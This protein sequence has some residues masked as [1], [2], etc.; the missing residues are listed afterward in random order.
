MK[1][2]AARRNAGDAGN[3]IPETVPVYCRLDGVC[4]NDVWDVMF[5][6]SGI[7]LFLIYA[8]VVVQNADAVIVSGT[9][10]DGFNNAGESTLQT[11]LLDSSIPSFPYW[12]NLVRYSDASGIY[13]GYNPST[14]RGWVLSANHISEKTSITVGGYS[15]VIIDKVPAIA[16]QN[17]TRLEH[18]GTPIDM[19]LYEFSVGGAAPIPPMPTVPI[20]SGTL[21]PGNSVL[22]AGRGMRSGA[23]TL[24]EDTT[25]PYAWGTPGESD[26]VPFRWGTNTVAATGLSA[27]GGMVSFS[28][29]FSAPGFGTEFE[30]QG[31]LGDSG[32]SGFVLTG[33]GDWMLAGLLFS[34]GDGP[35]AG[36]ATDPAGYGDLTYF[37]NLST[38][39]TL[40]HGITGSLIPEPTTVVYGF[41]A[42]MVLIVRRK[43][44]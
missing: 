21:S 35:D 37:A 2:H 25:A 42:T 39:R 34:V 16:N 36:T 22:M 14:M 24:A 26:A 7:R 4:S 11:F 27:G 3:D 15:Y 6:H 23:G 19:V 18:A 43:R 44:G 28:T 12:N 9:N 10:G 20:F 1:H 31:A 13:L 17:G 8:S 32:G 40:I 38:Y 5:R 33:G 41:L 30:G 29:D